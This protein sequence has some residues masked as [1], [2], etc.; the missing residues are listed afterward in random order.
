LEQ[1][2][3]VAV[4]RVKAAFGSWLSTESTEPHSL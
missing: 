2:E 4:A 1:E 3:L